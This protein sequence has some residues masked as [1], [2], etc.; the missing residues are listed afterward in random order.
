MIRAVF[1]KHSGVY[2][3]FE[4]KGHAGYDEYGMDICCAAVSSA[5]QTIANAMT[6]MFLIPA[7]V[8]VDENRI[9]V[10]VAEKSPEASRL[11][12]ALHMQLQL[13]A[14]DFEKN[15]TIRISEV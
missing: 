13:L 7:D 14:E 11:I 8:Q 1:E 5:V 15:I 10:R 2:T 6:E 3:G 12:A 4:V 9:A